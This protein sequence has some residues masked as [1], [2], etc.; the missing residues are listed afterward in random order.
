MDAPSTRGV[1]Q[2]RR[3]AAGRCARW[4]GNRGAP[5]STITAT[6]TGDRSGQPLSYKIVGLNR[7]Q[8][9][10]GLRGRHDHGIEVEEG[11]TAAALAAQPAARLPLDGDLL[12]R[13][14]RPNRHLAVDQVADR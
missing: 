11:A 7:V 10:G 9:T 12:A 8:P 2:S 4:R 5:R 6:R 14:E 13:A 1:R 3:R